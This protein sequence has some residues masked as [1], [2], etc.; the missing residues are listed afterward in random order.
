MTFFSSPQKNQPKIRLKSR[1]ANLNGLPTP[2]RQQRANPK[3]KQ[4]IEIKAENRIRCFDSGRSLRKSACEESFP[5]RWR[6]ATKMCG[7]GVFS[8]SV[9]FL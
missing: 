4:K 5:S 1:A 9:G 6:S 7:F 3:K 2:L 8:T